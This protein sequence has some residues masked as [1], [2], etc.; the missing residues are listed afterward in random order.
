M[1]CKNFISTVMAAAVALTAFAAAP[2]PARAD[3]DAAKIIFGATALGIIAAGIAEAND[4]DHA[5][6]SRHGYSYRYNN[7]R[8]VRHK[9]YQH[10]KYRHHYRKGYRHG[11]RD[12]YRHGR[13]DLPF[14]GGRYW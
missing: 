10:R 7:H 2:T 13:Y 3:S 1:T 11:Y 5:Y 6:V 14:N 12:G 9:H 4:N 8:H